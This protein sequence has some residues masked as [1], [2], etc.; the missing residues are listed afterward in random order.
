MIKF[1]ELIVVL[2]FGSI[3]IAGCSSD[4]AT[5][6]GTPAPV[7]NYF[8]LS[9]GTNYKYLVS[10]DDGSGTQISGSR[11]MIFMGTTMIE[12]T[13]YFNQNDTLTIDTTIANSVSFVRKTDR[14]TYYFLDTTGLY[15]SIPDSFRS[16]ISLDPEITTLS[17]PL[18]SGKT[19]VVFKLLLNIPPIIVNFA[20]VETNAFYEGSIE[21]FAVNL[22]SG[23]VIITV[24]KIRY[25]LKLTT[26]I[27]KPPVVYKAYAWY[28][29][30]IGIVR[31][32]GNGTVLNALASGLIDFDDT[33]STVIQE[34]SDY[35]IN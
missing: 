32:E 16:G 13:E 35:E 17:L 10:G 15:E 14:G 3:I 27:T 21:N 12:N 1:F 20:P 7:I 4:S 30:D 26:D 11:N 19:W 24:E 25:E 31:W 22:V 18:E 9:E 29:E 6:P 28:A 2:I 34:L 8:P 23:P 5:D 33:S